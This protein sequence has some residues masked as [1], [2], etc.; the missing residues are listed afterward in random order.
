M[1]NH[2]Q[3]TL[4]AACSVCALIHHVFTAVIQ[5]DFSSS[6]YCTGVLCESSVWFDFLFEPFR[7]STKPERAFAAF[8][9]V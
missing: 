4:T 5:D 8:S 1:S 2:D 7:T 3:T 6:N 9:V